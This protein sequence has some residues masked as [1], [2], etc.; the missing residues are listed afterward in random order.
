MA[1]EQNQNTEASLDPTASNEAPP[2]TT[3]PPPP[4]RQPPPIPHASS[5]V[6]AV[7]TPPAIQPPQKPSANHIAGAPARQYLNE[8]VTP[9]LL[10][11]MKAIAR[12]Q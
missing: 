2:T 9:Y 5:N 7:S 6:P 8:F 12:D 3:S 10:E 4:T 11:G 1:D